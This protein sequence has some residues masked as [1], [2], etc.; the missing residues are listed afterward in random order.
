MILNRQNLLTI[1][2]DYD[3]IF[4]VRISCAT[5]Y[6]PYREQPSDRHVDAAATVRVFGKG[7]TSCAYGVIPPAEDEGC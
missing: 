7:A 3:K 1:L 5:N 4:F 2:L 6:D